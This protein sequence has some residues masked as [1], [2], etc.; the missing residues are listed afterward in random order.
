MVIVELDTWAFYV[1]IV[2][3]NISEYVNAKQLISNLFL[4]AYKL[5][6][7]KILIKAAIK[8]H[9]DDG[10]IAQGVSDIKKNGHV[11]AGRQPY[12]HFLEIKNQTISV[13]FYQYFWTLFAY[14]LD[15]L[16][17]WIRHFW[18]MVLDTFAFNVKKHV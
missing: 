1:K 4:V 18:H 7:Y 8:A 6:L 16:C 3:K 15:T 14:L 9:E 2:S 5:F 17:K 12:A 13:Q 10:S 11:A